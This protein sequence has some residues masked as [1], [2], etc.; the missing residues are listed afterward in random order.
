VE[1]LPLKCVLP[2]SYKDLTNVKQREVQPVASSY[3]EIV[4]HDCKAQI[5]A[6]PEKYVELGKATKYV[7]VE[8]NLATKSNA[9]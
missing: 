2:S 8:H 6:E 4:V 5:L 3:L 7:Y 1:S 9:E